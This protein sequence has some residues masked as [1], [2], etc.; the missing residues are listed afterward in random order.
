MHLHPPPPKK[1]TSCK[2]RAG[3]AGCAG[4]WLGQQG[5]S[6]PPIIWTADKNDRKQTQIAAHRLRNKMQFYLLQCHFNS[7]TYALSV[8]K[9]FLYACTLLEN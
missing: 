4:E 5:D 2:R 6:S 3:R 9:P 1:M 8:G 7:H